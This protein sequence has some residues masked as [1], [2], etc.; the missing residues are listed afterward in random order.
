MMRCMSTRTRRLAALRVLGR[1]LFVLFVARRIDLE[2]VRAS[3]RGFG[4]ALLPVSILYPL[5]LGRL[6]GGP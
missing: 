1:L 2:A 3:Y 5:T 6:E 4:I